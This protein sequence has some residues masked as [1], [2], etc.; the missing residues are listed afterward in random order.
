LATSGYFFMAT[1]NRPVGA[2]LHLNF[3]VRGLI[4]N[5]VDIRAVRQD[6]VDAFVY[7]W[8]AVDNTTGRGC[9]SPDI[10]LLEGLHH[11]GVPGRRAPHH[12]GSHDVRNI[13]SRHGRSL[14]RVDTPHVVL[15]H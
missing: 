12:R 4:A 7:L 13:P 15:D 9:D 8:F 10:G 14:C 3:Q 6:D 1:D 5:E 11:L 2:R